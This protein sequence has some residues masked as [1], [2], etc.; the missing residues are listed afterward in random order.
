MNRNTKNRTLVRL[1]LSLWALA[2]LV[3]CVVAFALVRELAGS[4]RDPAAA[5]MGSAGLTQPPADTA[6]P[7]AP[8]G[9]RE[10][11]VYFG[12]EGAAELLPEP[13]SIEPGARTVENCRR[14]LEALIAGPKRPGLSPVLPQTAK[15]RGLY[16]LDD[17]ELVADFSSELALAHTRTKSAAME[18]L[19]AQA[20]AA[21]VT[22][23]AL[24]AQ[25]DKTGVR[26]V[27]LLF[28]GAPPPEQ[29]PAHVDLSQPLQ[30]DP[31]WIRT[32]AG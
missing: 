30:A 13:V 17:G 20:V 2:T 7:R 19:M 10:I 3:L 28:E 12:A 5:L 4:G 11:L 25:G 23:E 22:Q 27:R 1:G 15:L 31:K 18:A 26:Q 14:A 9:T 16:L 32:A 21:T 6:A 29:F 24:R 8:S